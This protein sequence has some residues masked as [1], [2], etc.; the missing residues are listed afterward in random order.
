ITMLFLVIAL[1]PVA[2]WGGEADAAKPADS[3]T[4]LKDIQYFAIGGVGYGGRTSGGEAALRKLLNAPDAREVF[5]NLLKD[6]T[7]EGQCYAL[8]GLSRVAPERFRVL[9]KEGKRGGFKDQKIQRRSGCLGYQQAKSEVAAEIAAGKFDS[10][11]DH[12]EKEPKRPAA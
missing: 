11:F 6:A 8:L 10:Y 3:I 12:P 9:W 2:A 1:A 7:W 4:V 5:E